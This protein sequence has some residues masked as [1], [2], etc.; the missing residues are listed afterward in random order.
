MSHMHESCHTKMGHII[1]EWGISHM[2][3]SCHVWMRHVT[4]V[5]HFEYEWF[6]SQINESCHICMKHVTYKWVIS[7]VTRVMYA[8]LEP[9]VAS[10]NI[11]TTATW[12]MSDGLREPLNMCVWQPEESYHIHHREPYM[13]WLAHEA[14]HIC[15]WERYTIQDICDCHTTHTTKCP[16]L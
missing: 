6:V 9:I 10:E 8:F 16:T 1:H 14:Y 5:S 4:Y 7:R 11:Y 12:G 15:F 2:N 13:M 3:E